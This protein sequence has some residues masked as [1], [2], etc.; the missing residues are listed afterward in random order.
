MASR[1]ATDL[2]GRVFGLLTVVSAVNVSG[3]WLWACRCSCGT[4]TNQTNSDLLTKGRQ[5][6][7]ACRAVRAVTHGAT[8][9]DEYR[10][11]SGVVTRATNSRTRY[12][13][14]YSLRGVTVCARWR[15]FEGFF[16][17]MG[18]RPSK[19][20]SI[21]RRENDGGYWCGKCPEC[22]SL[23]R[24]ANCRWATRTEQMRNVS[25]NRLLTFQGKTQCVADW[26]QELGIPAHRLYTRLHRGWSIEES[27]LRSPR[28]SVATEETV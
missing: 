24:P 18:P 19:D 11:W 23:G 15:Q 6:C 28:G 10:I 12:A 14:R 2:T 9:T 22:V 13:D 4:E 25:A 8:R 17:D 27:L 3:R 26:A 20:H 21:D 16:A 1:A 7:A 5:S